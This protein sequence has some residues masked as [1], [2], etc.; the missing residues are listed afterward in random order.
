MP[1]LVSFLAVISSIW[2]ST[3]IL[4]KQ[5][6]EDSLVWWCGKRMMCDRKSRVRGVLQRSTQICSR[7]GWYLWFKCT[8]LYVARE[9]RIF[10]RE[11][12]SIF[13]SWTKAD[14]KVRI[15]AK[16]T[17]VAPHTLIQQHRIF[18]FKVYLSVERLHWKLF[19]APQCFSPQGWSRLPGKEDLK[20]ATF[21]GVHFKQSQLNAA[22]PSTWSNLKTLV[23]ER[24]H[25]RRPLQSLTLGSHDYCVVN[26]RNLWMQ[27]RMIPF[28]L[29]VRIG[30]V[31]V[32]C[33]QWNAQISSVFCA[34]GQN[35]YENT[36]LTWFNFCGKEGHTCEWIIAYTDI[37]ATAVLKISWSL[38][39]A[40]HLQGVS[41]SWTMTLV[42]D[43]T[44]VIFRSN[45]FVG[46]VLKEKSIKGSD[47]EKPSHTWKTIFKVYL[48]LEQWH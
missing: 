18:I 8:V 37:T 30:L 21:V 11:T 25:S 41:F 2:W 36:F 4:R 31:C 34:T 1:T 35:Q 47:S 20:A 40:T 32:G 6:T 5:A 43:S 24:A 46:S 29:L 44:V 28:A 9:H 39:I 3:S 22:I 38:K 42:A 17:F 14:S 15:F 33:L 48:S 10:C 26:S 45:A 27:C 16:R 13:A 7:S 19:F 12:N 23:H